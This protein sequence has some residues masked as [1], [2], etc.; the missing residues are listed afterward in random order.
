MLKQDRIG[1]HD[2][3][4]ALG[5]HSLLATQVISRV[6]DHL[7]IELPLLRLFETPTIAGLAELIETVHVT[8]PGHVSQAAAMADGLEGEE[9]E[10]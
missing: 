1:A 5:G 9:G 4:F 3:F 2:D 10:L 8:E 7:D 6:K